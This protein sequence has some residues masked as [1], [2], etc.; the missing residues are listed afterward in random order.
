MH[1]NNA[2]RASGVPCK[3][4]GKPPETRNTSTNYRLGAR[5]KPGIETIL[6]RERQLTGV[7][8]SSVKQSDTGVA[9]QAGLAESG[10]QL[11]RN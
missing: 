10:R 7:V 1:A 11:K 6:L 5:A 8:L 2:V 9:A 3:Q 4:Y